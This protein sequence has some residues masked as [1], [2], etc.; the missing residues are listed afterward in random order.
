[1][2]FS[3][4]AALAA[5]ASPA[6]AAVNVQLN[7]RYTDPANATGGGTW[8]LL[9]KST[10]GEGVAGIKVNING[11]LGVT[12]VDLPAAQ[13]TSTSAAWNNTD[14]VF[15]YQLIAAGVTEVVAGSDLAP[16]PSA[17]QLTVGNGGNGNVAVDDL[18][19][20]GSTA[21]AW[22]NSSLIASGSWT[23]ARPSIAVT[24][25][26]V[27]SGTTP[28]A[29]T[30]GTVVT[31]GD[32]VGVDGLKPGDANRDGRVNLSDFAILSAN[33]NNPA[34][35]K[36]WD[37]GDFN[38]SVGGVNEVNLSDFAILSANYLQASPSPAASAAVGAVP[39][40]ASVGL[41]LVGLLGAAFASRRK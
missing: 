28:I 6:L 38:S 11:A 2:I 29:G 21:S 15:R 23:G 13:I 7:L 41:V 9:V 18:F 39:E 32:S 31:R 37:Q 16:V 33:Y 27:F 25:L 22:N 5:M 35:S 1:M 26:N 14:D 12:G 3:L 10:A 24:E 20:N 36:T 8:Q 19:T 40:P 4:C 17:G 30:L 34:A